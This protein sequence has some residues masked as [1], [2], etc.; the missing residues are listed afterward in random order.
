MTF[1]NSY[2]IYVQS[3][4]WSKHKQNRPIT[5]RTFQNN[6]IAENSSHGAKWFPNHN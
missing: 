5:I 2:E 6:K 4:P 3:K 1:I